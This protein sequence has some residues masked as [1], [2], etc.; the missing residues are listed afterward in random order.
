MEQLFQDSTFWVAISF[1]IFVIIAHKYGRDSV[2]LNLDHYIN[3]VKERIGHAED[4]RA[5]A[6]AMVAEYEARHAGAVAE[7]QAIVEEAAR[8]ADMLVAQGK[9]D[10]DARVA[11]RQKQLDAELKQME[12]QAIA[13]LRAHMAKLVEEAALARLQAE[14][15]DADTKNTLIERSIA[16]ARASHKAA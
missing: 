6:V 14:L 5:K 9:A 4:L 3:Q 12:E 16:A 10:L 7:A 1:T 2:L 11:M 13:E 15:Q 8:Q